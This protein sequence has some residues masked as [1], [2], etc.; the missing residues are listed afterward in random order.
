MVAPKEERLPISGTLAPPTDREPPRTGELPPGTVI[1]GRYAV[2]GV[3]ASGG[4]GT[5]Y[6][7]VQLTLDRPVAIK[8]LGTPADGADAR[9]F[10]AEA[11]VLSGLSHPAIVR[12]YDFGHAD[13]DGRP[14]SYLV[15]ERLR[16]QSLAAR[17]AAE[18]A[19]P[20]EIARDVVVQVL[21]A[22]AEIHARGILHRDVKPGNVM[23]V[24][25][26]SGRPHVKL[27]DFGIAR[28]THS[29]A[30]TAAGRYVGTP[31]YMAPEL[32][33]GEPASAA[34]DR[35]AVGVTLF[36][37]LTGLLPFDGPTE[38]SV[39]EQHLSA[40]R[41]DLRGVG[42]GAGCPSRLVAACARA[43]AVEPSDRFPSAEA[44]AEELRDALLPS[45]R[46]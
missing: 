17:L 40:P 31:Q 36:Q 46:P 2:K 38:A 5:I 34:T 26:R 23:V 30:L 29:P 16:G 43:L 24:P 9:R 6:D 10:L 22:L 45:L 25:D 44:F 27:V 18:A 13:L 7:A 12:V 41:P 8:C 37:L 42:G 19:L 32:V 21:S 33:R 1:G 11:R 3:L 39:F 4:M 14:S 20:A 15:M 28:S 35:Y